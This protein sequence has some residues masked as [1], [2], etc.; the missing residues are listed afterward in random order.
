MRTY[1]AELGEI[2]RAQTRDEEEIDTLQDRISWV[3]KELMG[4]RTWI[5]IYPYI[6]P[7][8]KA[9]YYSCTT[10][11]GVQTLGEEYVK[12]FQ[13]DSRRQAIPSLG[14]RFLFVFF[15]VIAPVLSQ[16]ALQRALRLLSHPSTSS[17]M[18]ISIRKNQK[19][20]K[21]FQEVLEWIRSTGI[22][23][24]HRLHLALFYIFGTHYNISLRATGIRF[25]SLSPQT[26]LKALK[27]FKFL[28][29]VTVAHTLSLILLI[30]SSTAKRISQTAVSTEVK[31]GRTTEGSASEQVDDNFMEGE[32]LQAQLMFTKCSGS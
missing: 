11:A 16:F 7:F 30:I 31:G 2:V 24:L 17:F 32:S 5:K 9:A 3:V 27:I 20:R 26:D 1:V 21:A 13:T 19:A 10:I 15:H 18:G 4:Q 29:Y 25:V 6:R 8:A 22:P 28:G 23:Q 12:I 14:T